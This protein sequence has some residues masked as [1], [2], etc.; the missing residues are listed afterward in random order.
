MGFG[1]NVNANTSKDNPGDSIPLYSIQ[2]HAE[3]ES[4]LP[5]PNQ[6]WPAIPKQ[7]DSSGTPYVSAPTGPD[8]IEL[9]K[10]SRSG[11]V[12]FTRRKISSLQ[13]PRFGN[14][15]VSS[16]SVYVLVSSLENV[17]VEQIEQEDVDGKT[18]KKSGRKRVKTSTT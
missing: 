13:E 17:R 3:K 15:F 7:C 16:G 18:R 9:L 12:G 2:F 6:D 10:F 5:A 8:G 1:Q 4:S 11:I 14:F